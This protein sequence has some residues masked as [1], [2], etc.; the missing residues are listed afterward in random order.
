MPFWRNST[1]APSSTART[2]RSRSAEEP[3]EHDLAGFMQVYLNVETADPHYLAMTRHTIR[4]FRSYD[5]LRLSFERLLAERSMTPG[6]FCLNTW[7]DFETEEE[8]YD[9]LAK[10]HAYL[11]L[12]AEEAPVPPG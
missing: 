8:M 3:R 1:H 4:G 12:D 5:A 6:E 7:L 2:A 10:V 11:F 9:Y